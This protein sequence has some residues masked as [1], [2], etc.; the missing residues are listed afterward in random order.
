MCLGGSSAWGGAIL[1]HKKQPYRYHPRAQ[2][3]DRRP[4]APCQTAGVHTGKVGAVR[5]HIEI[6]FA[7]FRCPLCRLFL[8]WR[9]TKQHQ[10]RIIVAQNV[11][12]F[13]GVKPH[14]V[15]AGHGKMRHSLL[16]QHHDLLGQLHLHIVTLRSFFIKSPCKPHGVVSEDRA[17][18]GRGH[19]NTC[20]LSLCKLCANTLVCVISL[21]IIIVLLTD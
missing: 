16:P 5:Q 4:P 3:P 19:S 1:S 10:F 18:F 13:G 15:V 6:A 9:N 12:E 2:M 20:F 21:L 11:N 7:Q 14:A 8:V 17:A